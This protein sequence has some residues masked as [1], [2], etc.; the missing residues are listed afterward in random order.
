MSARDLPCWAAARSLDRHPALAHGHVACVDHGDLE[1]RPLFTYHRGGHTSRL[2]RAAALG[3][4]VNA[5]DLPN[6]F[7]A[8]K[9]FV[10]LDV[11]ARSGTGGLG[12][13][14]CGR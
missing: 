9:R 10:Y 14:L 7:G 11:V 1:V 6:S 3:S 4:H 13:L 8:G 5:D 12:Q 2:V